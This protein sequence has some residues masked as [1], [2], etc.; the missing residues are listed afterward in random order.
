MDGSAEERTVS[1]RR[2]ML[3]GAAAGLLVGGGALAAVSAGRSHAVA[4]TTAAASSSASGDPYGLF[5]VL[6]STYD[7]G[8]DPTGTTDSYPA[9]QAAIDA[10]STGQGGIVYF[11][12]GQY[13]I[14]QPLVID[15]SGVELVGA[16]YGFI[17]IIICNFTSEPAGTPGMIICGVSTTTLRSYINIE[18]LA[19][20]GNLNPYSGSGIVWRVEIGTIKDCVIQFVARDGVHCSYGDISANFS[21]MYNDSLVMENVYVEFPGVSPDDT[22][23][24]GSGIWTDQYLTSSEFYAC[25]FDGGA[26]ASTSNP[27]PASP[28]DGRQMTVPFS[29]YGI[30]AQGAALKF[31]DCHPFTF[32]NN[33]MGLVGAQGIQVIG[34]EYESNNGAGITFSAATRC[35]VIGATFYDDPNPTVAAQ[36]VWIG[37]SSDFIEV[38]SCLFQSGDHSVPIGVEISPAGGSISSILIHHNRF[39]DPPAV[40]VN[41]NIPGAS[42]AV[43]IN[44]NKTVTVDDTSTTYTVSYVSITDN[45]IDIAG[46]YTSAIAM[47]DATNSNVAGNRIVSQSSISELAGGTANYNTYIGNDVTAFGGGGIK[48][49]GANSI[50]VANQE[51]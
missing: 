25:H 9:I 34:G 13:L 28:D 8:A 16:G 6:D 50:A 39:D 32:M 47:G 43:L 45:L 44:P 18:G 21:S 11:P 4:G 5:N 27:I 24:S 38:A 48:I 22:P 37:N 12:P 29:T 14:S 15:Y 46:G 20:Q 19:I 10:A 23:G 42:Y 33:G 3:T 1:S 30:Y 51:G 26:L 40:P 17:S 7:G 49:V 41:A 35:S 31:V 36:H 2:R